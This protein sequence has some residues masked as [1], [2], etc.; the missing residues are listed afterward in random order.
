MAPVRLRVLGSAAGGGVPQWNCRCSVCELA[1]AG[2]PRVQHRTQC[3]L[4]VCL[5]DD[6][7]ALLDCAPEILSQ[8]KSWHP[9]HPQKNVGQTRHSPIS[10]VLL[11]S[12]DIDHIAGLLSL[13]E[14]QPFALYATAEIHAVLRDNPIFHVLADGVVERRVVEVGQAFPLGGGITART[15]AVPG[16]RALYVP[17][18]GVGIG[19]EGEATIA[20]EISRGDVSA[21]YIPSCAAMSPSLA[22]RLRGAALVLF[23]GTVWHD[24][25]MIVA[26][27]GTKTGRRMGHMPVSGSDGSL[28]AFA[29]LQVARKVYIDINNTNPILVE[30]SPER[31]MVEDAGW[32]VAYDGM[33]IVL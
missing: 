2:D 24:D 28:A 7:H 15:L 11:T 23:D 13:R 14:R 5:G 17:G 10:A 30:G 22:D 6:G 25:E 12:G 32:E 9:L 3:S 20:V 1:W 27:V 33:E 19:R 8:I 26:G 16:K 31:R 18:E 4:A 21:F 29:D